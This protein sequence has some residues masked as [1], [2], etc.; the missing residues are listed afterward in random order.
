MAQFNE[1]GDQE[2]TSW[3]DRAVAEASEA[4][5]AEAASGQR[6]YDAAGLWGISDAT[7]ALSPPIAEQTIKSMLDVTEV[8]PP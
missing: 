5:V 4:N 1:I 7:A 2:K 6:A 3:T 8:G